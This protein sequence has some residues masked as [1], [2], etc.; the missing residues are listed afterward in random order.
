[1]DEILEVMKDP[2]IHAENREWI[3][4]FDHEQFG[5]GRSLQHR[6]VSVIT[7]KLLSEHLGEE[8][9]KA[10]REQ[11]AEFLES[12]TKKTGERDTP[13]QVQVL[14]RFYSWLYGYGENEVPDIVPLPEAR[15][16]SVL[17]RIWEQIKNLFGPQRKTDEGLPQLMH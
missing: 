3:L 2:N 6:T 9:T 4:R 13:V 16:K 7:L 12:Y 15:R 17:K 5:V 11:L 8:F 14:A 10:T 1:M